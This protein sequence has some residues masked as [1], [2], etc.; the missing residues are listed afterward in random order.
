VERGHP[1][2]FFAILWKYSSDRALIA[3]AEWRRNGNDPFL[4][5]RPSAEQLADR[6]LAFLDDADRPTLRGVDLLAVV[7]A[8]DLA[9]TGHEVLEGDG[10]VDHLGTDPVGL[11]DRLPAL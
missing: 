7:D 9:D 4:L 6:F 1:T 11:A 5:L 3:L 8:Q 2:V 10:T